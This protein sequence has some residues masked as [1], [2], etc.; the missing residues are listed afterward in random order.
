MGILV[1][2]EYKIARFRYKTGVFRYKTNG[3]RFREVIFLYAPS[4]I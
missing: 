4:D 1:K 3:F 2:N